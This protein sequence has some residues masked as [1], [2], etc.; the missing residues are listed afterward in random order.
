MNS[1]WGPAAIIVFGYVAAAFWQSKRFE[2]LKDWIKAE[3]GRVEGTLTGKLDTSGVKLDGI[4]KRLASLE[5]RVGKLEDA[6]RSPLVK[7]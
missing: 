2:D 7:A 5:V 4:D 6:I 1:N 3:I